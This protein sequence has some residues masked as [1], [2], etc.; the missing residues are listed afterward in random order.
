MLCKIHKDRA[1]Y[2]EGQTNVA[3][4]VACAQSVHTARPCVF[5]DGHAIMGFTQFFQDLVHLDRI[6]WPL[7][8]ARYWADT[9]EDGDRKRRRQ[10]EFLVYQHCPWELIT[11]VAVLNRRVEERVVQLLELLTHRPP[12]RVRPNWYYCTHR[13]QGSG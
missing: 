11:E 10:A 6:D 7:M 9:Q 3:H 12:V 13:M 5:T 2:P 8:G 1:L 4:L